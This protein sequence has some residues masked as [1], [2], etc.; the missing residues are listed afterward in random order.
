MSKKGKFAVIGLGQFGFAIARTLTEKGA[1]VIAIDNRKEVIDEIKDKVTYPVMLESTDK[2][3]LIS[4]DIQNM[5]AVVVAIGEDFQSLLLTTFILQELNVKRIIS[6]ANGEDQKKILTKMGIKELLS[7]EDEVGISVAQ[8][9]INPELIMSMP[10]PNDYEI[11]EITAPKKIINRSIEDMGLR[12][13]YE[14]NLVTL[15]REEKIEGEQE[16]R[17]GEREEEEIKT[18]HNIIGVPDSD[19]I[20]KE[21][22]RLL[23]FGKIKKI[24]RFIEINK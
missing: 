12:Q 14:L 16:K 17:E 5:D 21:N 4:Q 2:N 23:I 11:V 19:T 8:T 3:A 6:R 13:K 24:E 7:P 9:L 15:L 1:D 22:D 18:E 20:I 10:L